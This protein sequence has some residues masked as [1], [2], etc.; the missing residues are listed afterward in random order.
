MTVE[1]AS[2]L[3]SLVALAGMLIVAVYGE[4]K[5]HR[6]P[7]WLTFSGMSLGLMLGYLQGMPVFWGAL[8]GLAAG[9][10]FLFVFYL[11]GGV[12][13]GD[14]KLMGA[15]GALMGFK[16]M[17]PTLFYTALIGLCLA[18]LMLVW[19][20]DFWRRMTG[21]IRALAFWRKPAGE[22]RDKPEPILVPY[23]LAIALGCLMTLWFCDVK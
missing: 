9:F 23:G 19:R 17:P 10:G 14:V 2:G 7:N 5:E 6:I 12:G 18:L 4:V 13:G 16:L 21:M 20:R 1:T 3:A 8:G 22:G 15:V 11:F